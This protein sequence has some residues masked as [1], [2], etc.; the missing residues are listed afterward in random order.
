[1]G[2][3]ERGFFGR[4]GGG[5]GFVDGGVDTA[6]ET[7]AGRIAVGAGVALGAEGGAC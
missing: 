2:V 5:S 7:T 1:M 3:I 6:D 4:G